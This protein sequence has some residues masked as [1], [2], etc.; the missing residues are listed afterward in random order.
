MDIEAKEEEARGAPGRDAELPR[1][2]RWSSSCCPSCGSAGAITTGPAGLPACVLELSESDP[3]IVHRE[4]Y[5]LVEEKVPADEA[6][7]LRSGSDYRARLTADPEAFEAQLPFYRGRLLY[8]GALAGLTSL[9][10]DP[11]D[12]AFLL[13]WLGGVACLLALWRWSTLRGGGSASAVIGSLLALTA[14]GF[15]FEV[16][17]TATP[18]A[19]GRLPAGGALLV[20]ETR[21]AGS[22][23]SCCPSR[24]RRADSI[25][26]AGPL[27]VMACLLGRAD[28]GSPAARRRWASRSRWRPSWPGRCSAIPTHRGWSSTTPSSSTRPSPRSRRLRWTSPRGPAWSVRS[29]PQFKAP[30][31]CSSPWPRSSP[32]CSAIAAVVVGTPDSPSP[33][34]SSSVRA[35]FALVPVLWPRLMFPYWVLGALALGRGR[36]STSPRPRLGRARSPGPYWRGEALEG[37]DARARKLRRA[38]SRVGGRR[39][40]LALASAVRAGKD[41]DGARPQ[42][43]TPPGDDDGRASR[44][45]EACRG[46]R[47]CSAGR[48]PPSRSP[49]VW[50]ELRDDFDGQKDPGRSRT[51]PRGQRP[52]ETNQV[53][54]ESLPPDHACQ[55]S[56]VGRA[57]I[58]PVPDQI[59][60]GGGAVHHH[61]AVE[62]CAR[63]VTGHEAVEGALIG[64]PRRHANLR[65]G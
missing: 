24:S 6:E 64:I 65:E 5:A 43:D 44:Q 9:A 36:H 45:R 41:V 62:G 38:T 42:G 46:S 57:S 51:S 50:Q 18:D 61:A 55:D 28:A 2:W 39:D 40:A 17:T 4:V 11:V 53:T 7:A 26:L 56:V 20:L 25:A 23:P 33:S 37:P 10:G 13:S 22:G 30:A 19:D 59:G 16:P 14:I 58:D 12:A 1:R 3:A 29:L 54:A 47:R 34:R 52:V 49:P 32:S 48:A 15:W 35:H 60:I 8:I 31:P 63:R 27:L 21:R